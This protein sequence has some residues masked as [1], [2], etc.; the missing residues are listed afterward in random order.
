MERKWET[1]AAKLICAAAVAAAV[2]IGVNCLWGVL[3][4]FALA[5]GLSLA[6]HPAARRLGERTGIPRGVWAVLL[7]LIAIG[8]LIAVCCAGAARALKELEELLASLVARGET[9]EGARTNLLDRL[10]SVFGFERHEAL[11]EWRN[12]LAER[13]LTEAVSALSAALPSLAGRLLGAVPSAALFVLVTVIAGFYFCLEPGLVGRLLV[14]CLPTKLSA[15][16]PSWRARIRAVSFRYLRAYLLLLCVTFSAL[17]VGFLVLRVRYALLLSLAVAVV[18]LLPVLGVGTVLIP[19]AIVLLLRR[20][21]YQGFGL[22]IL[23]AAVT[24]LRQ[25][26]EPRLIGKSLGLHPLAALVAGYAGWRWFGVLGMALGPIAA[27]AVK[28]LLRGVEDAKKGA[29]LGGSLGG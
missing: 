27:T 4:P 3:L 20:Q 8:G 22:L 15:R 7:L 11:R 1:R 29:S 21:F 10:V 19:W 9:A 16:L 13:M 12:D 23:Y 14:A 26:M 2:A 17:L 25:I 5:W 28:A 24:V 6:I 18:D